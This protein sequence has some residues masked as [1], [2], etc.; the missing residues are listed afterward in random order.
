MSVNYT[1]PTINGRLTV[2]VNN[3]DAGSSFGQMRLI[4][5]QST[6]AVCLIPLQKPC[7]V[8]SGGILTFNTP[9]TGTVITLASTSNPLLAADIE[10]SAG[11]VIVSGLTIGVSTAYDIVTATTSVLIGENITLTS[12]T[13]TGV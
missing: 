5:T 1:T 3:I 7:G 6:A 13:I 2:V 4:A 9:I 10:D 12:A 11:N 8:V